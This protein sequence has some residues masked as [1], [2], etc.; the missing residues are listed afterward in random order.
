MRLERTQIVAKKN[1]QN[2]NFLTN[3]KLKY[4]ITKN[5]LRSTPKQ[6]PFV[7]LFVCSALGKHN[8]QLWKQY[9]K[10]PISSLEVILS[11]FKEQ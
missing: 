11:N 5:V 6:D 7:L 3:R 2:I 4:L 10:S 8:T 1:K 9:V